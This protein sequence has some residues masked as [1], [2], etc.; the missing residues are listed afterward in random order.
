MASA[1]SIT[2]R[3]ANTEDDNFLRTLYASTRQAEMS[4]LP[5]PPEVKDDFVRM[6]FEA[7]RTHYL[8]AFPDAEHSIILAAG[9]PA[10]RLYL[11]RQEDTILI[12]D[13]TLLPEFH[14]QGIGR[15]VISE[16]QSEATAAGKS[17]SGHVGRWN[18]AQA[19][20]QRMGFRF[21]EVDEMYFRFSWAS[22]CPLPIKPC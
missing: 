14:R 3:P 20:W 12:V 8:A 1:N 16:L 17:L 19:F 7:Q 4:V 15:V 2:L 6:Q 11:D 21:A 13:L 9:C 10:G 18:P 5:G 22:V